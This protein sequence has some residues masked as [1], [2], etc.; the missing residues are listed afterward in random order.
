MK[1][2][3]IIGS[4]LFAFSAVSLFANN[5]NAVYNGNGQATIMDTVP[6]KDSTKK[7]D[8]VLIQLRAPK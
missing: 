4:T 2:L 5:T 1:K 8:T 3:L 7:K 6:K